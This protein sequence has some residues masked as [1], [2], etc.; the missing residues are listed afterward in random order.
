MSDDL[1]FLLHISDRIMIMNQ[2][3]IQER[4]RLA[5]PYHTHKKI[6]KKRIASLSV[7]I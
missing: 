2:G 1:S 5:E 4:G 3:V 7:G 6:H